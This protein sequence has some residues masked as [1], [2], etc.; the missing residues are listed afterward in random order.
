[1][2]LVEEGSHHS[3][4]KNFEFIEETKENGKDMKTVEDKDYAQYVPSR[5]PSKSHSKKNNDAYAKI[6][7]PEGRVNT[8][9]NEHEEIITLK[10]P[11]TPNRTSNAQNQLEIE[12]HNS[13]VPKEGESPMARK[14]KKSSRFNSLFFKKQSQNVCLLT[15]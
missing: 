4:Q 5:T 9:E 3:A 8:A 14:K 11:A 15:L 6:D 2:L 10:I 13:L 12:R 7:E 1:M